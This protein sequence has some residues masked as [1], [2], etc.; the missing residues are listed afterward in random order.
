MEPDWNGANGTPDD[1]WTGITVVPGTNDQL[2]VEH[3]IFVNTN[4][5]TYDGSCI[6]QAQYG[7]RIV[8]RDNVVFNMMFEIHG[9]CGAI[10]GR[11]WE[12]YNNICTNAQF[13]LRGGSGYIYNNTGT[14]GFFTMGTECNVT[15]PALYQ[16]GRGINQTLVPAHVW[17]NDAGIG[18]PVLNGSGYCATFIANMV[19]LNVDVYDTSVSYT[20]YTDPYP[21][22]AQSSAPAYLLINPN[23]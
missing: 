22:P 4:G 12:F 9:S 20:T 17:G 7:S 16:I 1:G 6:M 11:W 15:Y 14:A 19:T 5:G 10:Y 18:N 13:C 8:V 23:K 3:N 2:Y 21:F